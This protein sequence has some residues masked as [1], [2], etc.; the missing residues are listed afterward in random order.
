MLCDLISALPALIL[1][2]AIAQRCKKFLSQN[3]GGAHAPPCTCLRAPMMAGTSYFYVSCIRFIVIIVMLTQAVEHVA[4]R[5]VA[6]YIVSKCR[7]EQMCLQSF[8]NHSKQIDRL[9][10]L[11]LLFFLSASAR[12]QDITLVVIP[13]VI[14]FFAIFIMLFFLCVLCSLEL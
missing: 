10:A 7:Y 4:L 9:L 12:K 5:S 14:L 2:T 6:H 8:K 3:P 13:V 11:S 1:I